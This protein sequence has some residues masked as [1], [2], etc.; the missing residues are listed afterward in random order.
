M[1]QAAGS[2][3][4]AASSMQQAAS[5]MQHTACSMQQAAS[6]KQQA[7]SSKLQA[8]SS[9]QQAACSMQH[10]AYSMQ[11]S[12]GKTAGDGIWNDLHRA[13][14][15]PRLACTVLMPV[16]TDAP[17]H[18]SLLSLT[19]RGQPDQSQEPK[20]FEVEYFDS[21][22]SPDA[23]CM[24]VASN[25]LRLLQKLL[26]PAAVAMPEL[27]LQAS[28]RSLK[29]KDGFSCGYWTLRQAEALYRQHRG[30]GW[31]CLDIPDLTWQR[32][33]WNRWLSHLRTH[34]HSKKKQHEK[35]LTA[36]ESQQKKQKLDAAVAVAKASEGN[37]CTSLSLPPPPLPDQ[38]VAA[39]FY[40]CPKCRHAPRGCAQCN[41]AKAQKLVAKMQAS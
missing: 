40:G 9:R 35:P 5:S 4:Q 41:P 8:A 39:L 11:H 15:L 29:Q 32:G 22:A 27:P 7:A 38:G 28:N 31:R 34:I 1:Q 37:A 30:E 12:T 25:C 20:K 18:W 17:E 36:E 2:K 19:R 16:H 26:G 10:A 33:E 3:Q 6:S 23:R 24:A 21:M 13:R 14:E